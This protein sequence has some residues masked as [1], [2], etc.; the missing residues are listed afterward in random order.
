MA[1]QIQ[2][3]L[4]LEGQ[5]EVYHTRGGGGGR[6]EETGGGGREERLLSERLHGCKFAKV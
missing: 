5:S 3:H 6:G 2:V 4:C 1:R